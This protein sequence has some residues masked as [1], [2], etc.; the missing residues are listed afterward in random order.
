MARPTDPWYVP[1]VAGSLSTLGENIITFP[2]EYIKVGAGGMP[3]LGC[4]GEEG[5]SVITLRGGNQGESV[6]TRPGLR[7]QSLLP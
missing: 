7:L 4:F 2:L 5:D 3:W 6:V 1:V